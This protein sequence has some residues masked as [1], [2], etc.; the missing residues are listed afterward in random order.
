MSRF[1]NWSR[2]GYIVVGI[3][4]TLILVPT[5]I[6]AASVAYNGI[7]GTNG[8]TATVNDAHVTSAGQLTVTEAAPKSYK[9]YGGG[10]SPGAECVAVSPVLP[11]GFAFDAQNISVA[12][13]DSSAQTTSGS[14]NEF[15][16][17]VRLEA[18]TPKESPCGI[19]KSFGYFFGTAVAPGGNTGNVELPQ[20]PGVVVPNGYQI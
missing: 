15:G 17:D 10:V 3:I 13:L 20:S 11:T 6:A 16:G 19:E 14:T 7:E 2:G 9:I 5:G 8:T 1:K 4:A 12:I 18:A